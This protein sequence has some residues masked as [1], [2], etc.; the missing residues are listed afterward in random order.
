MI[1]RYRDGRLSVAAWDSPLRPVVDGLAA[2]LEERLDSFDLSGALEAIWSVVRELNR[3]VEERAPWQ[4]AKD[5]ARAEELDRAL[6][7][8][9]DGLR[10]VAVAL[11]PYT[12]ETA[13]RILAALGQPED[14]A[15][16]RVR[17]GATE[18]A[19]AIVPAQPLFPRVEMPALLGF[20][21]E[22]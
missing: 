22:R 6:F 2:E 11:S 3:T 1:A 15:W 18:A 9:A 19:D 14:V 20:A 12:P 5:E 8:L 4:L 16:E 7:D 10:A 17:Y 21:E 13:R